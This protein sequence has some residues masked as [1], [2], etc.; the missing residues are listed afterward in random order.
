MKGGL[1]KVLGS[2]LLKDSALGVKC[3]GKAIAALRDFPRDSHNAGLFTPTAHAI[4]KKQQK[5]P[6]LSGPLD[7]YLAILY[8]CIYSSFIQLSTI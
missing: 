5:T 3:Q 4:V 7:T 8:M 2:H 6:S 1:L